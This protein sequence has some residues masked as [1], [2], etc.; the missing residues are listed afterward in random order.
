M[1]SMAMTWWL[2][3]SAPAMWL[4]ACGAHVDR[5]VSPAFTWTVW[6][7][8]QSLPPALLPQ[9]Q[10][11]GWR[12]ELVPSLAEVLPGLSDAAPRGWP[13]GWTWK[14][15]DAVHLPAEKRILFAEWRVARDG[16]WV[17]CHRVTGVVRHEL[18]HAWDA[19]CYPQG[20]FSES[21]QF[22][23]VY[24]REVARLPASIRR[25]LGY[26]VQPTGAGRQEAFAELAAL[27][28]GGGSSPH[29]EKLLRQSFPRTLAVVQSSWNVLAVPVSAGDVAASVVR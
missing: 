15:V 5:R 28:W 10:R 16:R 4:E 25:R 6:A 8:C 1:M 27:V 11:R 9:L 12:V 23:F 17:R 19:A 14:N 29:L 7:S 21:P 2:V 13:A 18:A 22:R 26:F 24:E 3:V 20:S